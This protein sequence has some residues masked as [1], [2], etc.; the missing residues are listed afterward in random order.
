MLETMYNQAKEVNADLSICNYNKIFDN[1]KEQNKLNFK[2][3][4]VDINEMSLEEYFCKY[5]FD[6]IHGDE[7][8]N[9]IYKRSIIVENNIRFEKSSEIFADDKLFNL[10]Y[11]LFTKKITDT[12][13]SFYNYLQRTGSL[14]SSPKPRL[15]KQYMT[16]IDKFIN[17]AEKNNKSKD[18]NHLYPLVLL[19][20]LSGGISYHIK[21]GGNYRD[22][23]KLIKDA[24]ESKNYK[25]GMVRLFI[26]NQPSLYCKITNRG[27]AN[28]LY[29]RFYGLLYYLG[30]YRL[31][32][33]IDSAGL[34][35]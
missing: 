32:Y 27:I 5:T 19:S 29:L 22:L 28:Q 7:V 34:K 21:L 23:K 35:K 25:K 33:F 20:L 26:E 14:M 17:F 15:I 24:S 11:I 12:N 4:I 13:E 6:H 1:Y 31:I 18:I 3:E 2:K 9:K 30:L 8:W 16:P 10:Y